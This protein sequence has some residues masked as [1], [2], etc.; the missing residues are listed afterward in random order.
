MGREQNAA[1]VSAVRDGDLAAARAALDAG[2]DVE[3]LN[4]ARR[5]ARPCCTGSDPQARSCCPLGATWPLRRR[6]CARLLPVRGAGRRRA[7]WPGLQVRCM[8]VVPP[9]T[10]GNA[11]ACCATAA[12]HALL[13]R[14]GRGHGAH[15]RRLQR[16]H[17]H[18]E[19]PVGARRRHGS[20]AHGASSTHTRHLAAQRARSAASLA[21]LEHARHALKHARRRARRSEL[22]RP[23]VCCVTERL[24]PAALCGAIRPGR[25]CSGAGGARRGQG[26]AGRGAQRIIRAAH[27]PV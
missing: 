21:P 27:A 19:A 16:P 5:P 18:R 17:G 26:R 12:P 15:L 23:H 1:L 14:A 11:D 6:R 22:T 2:A 20:E 8:L 24:D 13:C 4:M 3:S 7:G 10:P 9:A 25:S